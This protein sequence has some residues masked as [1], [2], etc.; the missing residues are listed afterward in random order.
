MKK[1]FLSVFILTGIFSTSAQADFKSQLKKNKIAN[2]WRCAG[3]AKIN[4]S[5]SRVRVTVDLY[6]ANHARPKM[7]TVQIARDYLQPVHFNS[8]Y[9][10]DG[11][12]NVT[13]QS[14]GNIVKFAD[15]YGCPREISVNSKSLDLKVKDLK[16]IQN[17]SWMQLGCFQ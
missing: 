9:D 6:M 1:L 4:G 5:L 7:A 11:H 14:P 13:L 8:I 12:K 10:H 16:C 17:L 2:S 15:H 3:N